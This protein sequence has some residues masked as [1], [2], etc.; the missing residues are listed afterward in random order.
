MGTKFFYALI[1]TVVGAAFRLLMFFTGF[2]T[3]KLATGQYLNWVM[4]PVVFAIYWF[5]LKAIRDERPNQAISYGQAVGNGTLLALIASIMSAVYN[6]IHLKFI[7]T[8]FADY[9]LE[10]IRSKW[11]EQ[12]MSEDQ[13]SKAEGFVRMTLSPGAQAI[14]TIFFG[15]I[16]GLI[17]VL[18]VAAFV[19]RA[20]P[21]GTEPPPM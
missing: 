16:F 12:G 8:S 5:A 13:M 3:E 1:L 17:I 14:G 6:F 7:N 2:E 4:L 21:E 10:V 11:A 15:V 18:I 9:Q 19:K 20:A